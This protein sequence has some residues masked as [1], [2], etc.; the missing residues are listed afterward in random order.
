MVLFFGTTMI[1]VLLRMFKVYLPA[2]V[3]K[4]ILPILQIG[5]PV[6]IMLFGWVVIL[7]IDLAKHKKIKTF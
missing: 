4:G 7:V 5:L 3:E 2:I 6:L 1:S